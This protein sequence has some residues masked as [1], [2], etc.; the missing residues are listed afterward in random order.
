[1]HQKTSVPQINLNG[2]FYDY[3][4]NY[5]QYFIFNIQFRN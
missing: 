1:M 2:I 5:A 3:K 4:T